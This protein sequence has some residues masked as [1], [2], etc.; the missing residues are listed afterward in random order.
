MGRDMRVVLLLIASLVLL[1]KV[2][3]SGFP[4]GY[5]NRYDDG[6][7]HTGTLVPR[8]EYRR[9]RKLAEELVLRESDEYRVRHLRRILN[10]RWLNKWTLN[11]RFEMFH[12]TCERRPPTPFGLSKCW[13]NHQR[14]IITCTYVVTVNR[15]LGLRSIVRKNCWSRLDRPFTRWPFTRW[16]FKRWPS[17]RARATQQDHL[18]GN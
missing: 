16:P 13:H 10:L 5:D 14:P 17:W 4:G 11:I 12:S 6:Y 8:G 7:G 3:E 2:A 15:Y 9:F 18:D 1:G